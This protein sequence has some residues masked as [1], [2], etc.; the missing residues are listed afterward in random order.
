MNRV[1]ATLSACLVLGL[2]GSAFPAQ[3]SGES[4]PVVFLHATLVD[5]TGAPAVENAWV[6]ME[7]GRIA[8]V[9]TGDVPAA[10]AR[11]ARWQRR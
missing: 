9:G 11:V 5:G 7:A 2:T 10:G 1:A 6:R 8:G 3:P 4:P